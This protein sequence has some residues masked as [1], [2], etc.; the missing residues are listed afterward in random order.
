MGYEQ[1]SLAKSED[2]GTKKSALHK[3]QKQKNVEQRFS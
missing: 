1:N 3:K 2:K